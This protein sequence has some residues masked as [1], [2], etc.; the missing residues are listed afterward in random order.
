[1][2]DARCPQTGIPFRVG[3]KWTGMVVRL[4]QSGPLR[5]GE[6]RSALPPVTAKVLTATLRAMERDG[7]VT[8]T[9]HDVRVPAHVEY[10]LT[11]LG[12]SL[13]PLVDAARAWCDEHLDEL[14]AARTRAPG[15][16]PPSDPGSAPHRR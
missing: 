13:V 1:M 14:R 9:V 8:R 16:R 15:L 3:D 5:F 4:L 10:A 2:I 12:D 7:F 11:P 6:L